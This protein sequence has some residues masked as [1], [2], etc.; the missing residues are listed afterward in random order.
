MST[1]PRSSSS[2]RYHEVNKKEVSRIL[3]NINACL[4]FR[5][6]Q[7]LSPHKNFGVYKWSNDDLRPP[8]TLLS[9]QVV[10]V[11]LVRLGRIWNAVRSSSLSNLSALPCHIIGKTCKNMCTKVPLPKYA[12]PSLKVIVPYKRY[13]LRALAGFW[14]AEVP[15]IF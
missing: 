7:F 12:K 1:S 10:E 15:I 11:K 13:P 3:L 8:P 6:R 14:G 2:S 5:F 4:T 9:F